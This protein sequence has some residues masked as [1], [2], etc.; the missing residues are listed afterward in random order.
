MLVSQRDD[1]SAII[2]RYVY[3]VLIL[4]AILLTFSRA[5]WI[6]TAV[7]SVTWLWFV[8]PR[9]VFLKRVMWGGIAA[10]IFAILVL[11]IRPNVL[12]RAASSRDHLLRPLE[13]VHRIWKE[14]FGYGLGT[15]GP[16]SNRTSDAC[17]HLEEGAD[18]SWAA[19][20]RDLCVFVGAAQVQP[21]DKECNCPFLPENWYLQIGVELGILGFVIFFVFIILVVDKLLILKKTEWVFLPFLG[22]SIAAL[23]LHAWEDAAVAY[24]LW[25]LV[26][27]VLL[28]R[29]K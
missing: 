24:T 21:L 15:A 4:I 25:L 17:V 20:R 5:A 13:A 22:I 18:A 7:I 26:A 2:R 8:L 11:I 19:D 6:S 3:L 14:P 9:S 10:A 16:A 23:F 12:L 28:T 1:S 27:S 29:H